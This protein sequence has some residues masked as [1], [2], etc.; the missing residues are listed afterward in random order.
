MILSIPNSILVPWFFQLCFLLFLYK[1]VWRY[2]ISLLKLCSVSLSLS[3][4]VYFKAGQLFSSESN[5]NGWGRGLRRISRQM[6]RGSKQNHDWH[7]LFQNC[8]MSFSHIAVFS[9]HAL[10][11]IPPF[12]CCHFFVCGMFLFLI[13]FFILHI[14]HFSLYVATSS[15]I[16][17]FFLCFDFSER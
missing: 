2:W 7:D 8:F 15:Y 5:S 4:K 9:L 13:F 12:I 11:L 10:C 1:N 6:R 16:A 3:W 17:I 14:W